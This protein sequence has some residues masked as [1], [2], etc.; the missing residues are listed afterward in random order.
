MTRRCRRSRG[1]SG[2]TALILDDTA[3]SDPSA[4]LPLVGLGRLDLAGTQVDSLAVIQ[5]WS[6]L[7]TVDLARTPITS[8]VGAEMMP[9]LSDLDVSMT[10]ID[11]LDPLVA[12]PNFRNGDRVNV[13]STGLD[14]GDCPAILELRGRSAVVVSEVSCEAEE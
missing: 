1:A 6:A 7:G 11:S 9:R 3:I 2:L 5:Q 12:L 10:A 4:L 13:S 14:A 8:L